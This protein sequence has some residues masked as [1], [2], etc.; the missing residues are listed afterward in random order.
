MST[1]FT[2][3][4]AIP[5]CFCESCAHVHSEKQLVSDR[6]CCIRSMPGES[7]FGASGL[8]AMLT[9]SCFASPHD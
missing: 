6:G 2:V 4:F 8:L 1:I 9:L 5:L 7:Q 3:P